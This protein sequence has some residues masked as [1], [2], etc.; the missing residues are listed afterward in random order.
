[1][2]PCERGSWIDAE[3]Y[4]RESPAT[5]AVTQKYRQPLE[6]YCQGAIRKRHSM[7]NQ[8]QNRPKI[9]TIL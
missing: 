5:L 2:T 7:H 6:D 4:I 1:M 9:R 8:N 3:G